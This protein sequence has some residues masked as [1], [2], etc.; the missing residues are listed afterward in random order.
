[1]MYWLEKAIEGENRYAD[2]LYALGEIYFH[3]SDGQARDY[4]KALKY[5]KEAGKLGHADALCN[6]VRVGRC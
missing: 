6:V 3:G 2:A 4:V 5:F 1:M